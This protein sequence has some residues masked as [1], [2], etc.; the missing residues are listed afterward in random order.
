MKHLKRFNSI[1]ENHTHENEVSSIVDAVIDFLDGLEQHTH[2][3][4]VNE[5]N[6]SSALNC[7]QRMHVF[8]IN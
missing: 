4:E 3:S 8:R 2:K 7:M 5:R 1:N 6:L